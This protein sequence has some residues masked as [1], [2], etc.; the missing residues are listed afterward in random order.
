MLHTYK[1]DINVHVYTCVDISWQDVA[2]G[3]FPSHRCNSLVATGPSGGISMHCRDLQE[4][5]LVK[6][7]CWWCFDVSMFPGIGL[8]L[9]VRWGPKFQ[10][11]LLVVLLR[12]HHWG[13]GVP[14]YRATKLPRWWTATC[15]T[16]QGRWWTYP[17]RFPYLILM[18]I[19]DL[20][21]YIYWLLSLR[22]AVFF[23]SIV[24]LIFGFL[25]CLPVMRA[26]VSTDFGQG[27]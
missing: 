21:I 17:P 23:K 19:F 6:R 20:Y 24:F 22:K 3:W 14:S 9:G 25:S 5:H 26:F 12:P 7:I 11:S 15:G 4:W 27:E 2:N 13:G 1:L 18:N 8:N 10:E 16:T